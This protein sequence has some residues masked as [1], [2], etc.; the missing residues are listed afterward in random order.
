MIIRLELKKF[1]LIQLD[2]L[3]SEVQIEE[4]QELIT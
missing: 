3:K 2:S 4:S 1:M